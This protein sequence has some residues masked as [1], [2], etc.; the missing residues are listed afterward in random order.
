MNMLTKSRICAYSVSR[1]AAMP[2]GGLSYN[3]VGCIVGQRHTLGRDDPHLPPG[4]PWP[5]HP[6]V[7]CL[8]T[9]QPTAKP[10]G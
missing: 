4:K 9:W 7:G 10:G 3:T 8:H 2:V 6:P 1:E 5:R